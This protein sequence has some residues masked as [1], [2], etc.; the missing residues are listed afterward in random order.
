MAGYI[1]QKDGLL[2]TWALNFT[3]LLTADPTRYGL[4]AGDAA[5]AA[6]SYTDFAAAYALAI[7]PTT[8]TKLNV[9]TKDAKRVIMLQTL[10][11]YALLIRA[12][13]GVSD[14]DKVAIGLTLPDPT[15]TPVPVPTTSPVLTL[16]LAAVGVQA[17]N[18]ADQLTPTRKAKPAGVVSALL[19]RV[20]A[21]TPATSMTGAVLARIC[22][23][24]DNVLNTAGL[25]A[26]NVATYWAQWVNRKG[27]LGP[28]SEPASLVIVN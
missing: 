8:R 27:E 12:N 26:G 13:H 3:T 28:L 23:R 24:A 11:A 4:V 22:T 16:T 1:P 25:T 6:A 18:I 5:A 14:A 19:Y 7:N 2:N 20:V 17:L 15:P 10:R 9:T 21:P